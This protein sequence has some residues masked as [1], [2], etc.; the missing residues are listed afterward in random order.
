VTN[1]RGV[2]AGGTKL[3]RVKDD[4]FF[5]SVPYV[6]SV[7]YPL[8]R[9]LGAFQCV[10]WLVAAWAHYDAS[11]AFRVSCEMLTN[12]TGFQNRNHHSVL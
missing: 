5:F 3:S 2:L 8:C 9:C 4:R 12:L 7:C 10:N 11:I 6:R 1:F